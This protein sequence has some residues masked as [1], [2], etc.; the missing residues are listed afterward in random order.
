MSYSDGS[1]VGIAGRR[2]RSVDAIGAVPSGA[3]RAADPQQAGRRRRRAWRVL[4]HNARLH[5]AD[6]VSYLQ[7]GADADE[8]EAGSDEAAEHVV[9]EVGPRRHSTNK[10]L[11]RSSRLK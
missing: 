2:V 11:K 5:A 7:E 8:G 9:A 4:L 1:A 6:R 3:R 10:N